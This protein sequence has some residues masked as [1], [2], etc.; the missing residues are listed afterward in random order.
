MP[1]VKAKSNETDRQSNAFCC[2]C[3]CFAVRVVAGPY[4]VPA[5]GLRL[6][7][8][9]AAPHAA[10]KALE[11][12]RRASTVVPPQLIYEFLLELGVRRAVAGT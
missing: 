10:V 8:R 2:D 5:L 6:S 9:A 4:A 3:G 7:R 1:I 11:V 12:S